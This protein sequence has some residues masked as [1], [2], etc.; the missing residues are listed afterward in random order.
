MTTYNFSHD[1]S[2]DYGYVT[3]RVLLASVFLL[4]G[5]D[6]GFCRRDIEKHRPSP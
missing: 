3:A 6:P 2:R 5:Y 4:T 1:P